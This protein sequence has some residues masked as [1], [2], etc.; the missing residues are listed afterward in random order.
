MQAGRH[1][2]GVQGEGGGGWRCDS[3]DCQLVWIWNLLDD[4][5]L[6]M[7]AEAFLERFN[8][9][10]KTHPEFGQHHPTGLEAQN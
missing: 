6:G 9:G 2:R 1:T 3:L 10:G 8:Q 5:T 7:S 4:T